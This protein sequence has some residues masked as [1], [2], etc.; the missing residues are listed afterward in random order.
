[1][2]ALCQGVQFFEFVILAQRL[3]LD[4]PGGIGDRV[5]KRRPESPRPPRPRGP[6]AREPGPGAPGPGSF[7]GAFAWAFGV[8][9][10]GRRRASPPERVKTRRAMRIHDVGGRR[11]RRGSRGPAQPVRRDAPA[12][13]GPAGGDSGAGSTI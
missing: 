5:E 13:P 10:F 1:M 7:L 3:T 12:R 4:A 9:S 2:D 6:R 11:I 8:R